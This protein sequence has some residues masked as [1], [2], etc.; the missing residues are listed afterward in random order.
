MGGAFHPTVDV[1]AHIADHV[2]CKARELLFEGFDCN[3][4][5]LGRH[6]HRW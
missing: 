2:H 5:L 6:A 4:V 1:H 3:P